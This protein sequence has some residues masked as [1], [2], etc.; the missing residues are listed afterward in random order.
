MKLITIAGSAVLLG[1]FFQLPTTPPMKMGLWEFTNTMTMTM[2]GA[3]V[4]IPQRTTKMQVC[5]TPES[6]AK[7]LMP[8]TGRPGGQSNGQSDCVISNQSFSGH[9]Y[10]M[11]MSC[12]K[13]GN[14]GHVTA[15]WDTPESSHGTTHMELNANGRSA[16]LDSTMSSHFVSSDCGAVKP[17]SPVPVQ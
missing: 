7:N 6:W 4:N 9:T 15:T 12:P 13:S 10:S 2:Q 5:H 11:D 1:G 8:Q 16:T 3:N 14:K 17:G